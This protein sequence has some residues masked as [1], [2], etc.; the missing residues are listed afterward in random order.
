[1]FEK[2]SARLEEVQEFEKTEVPA[3]HAKDWRSFLGMYA[4]E[5]TAGTEFVIGP[6]F[7]AHGAAAADLVFG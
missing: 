7:V 5:H 3:A 4:G 1:M 2:L 6:L